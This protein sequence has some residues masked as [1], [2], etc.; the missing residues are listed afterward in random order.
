MRMLILALIFYV[1]ACEK[2]DDKDKRTQKD[3]EKAGAQPEGTETATP[4]SPSGNTLNPSASIQLKSSDMIA[5]SIY[6]TLGRGKT[7][8]NDG[9]TTT[10]VTEEFKKNFGGTSGLRLGEI[11]ADSPST[12]YLLALTI[13][14]ELAARR[15]MEDINAGNGELCQCSTKEDADAMLKRALPHLNFTDAAL[16]SISDQF[17]STCAQDPEGAITSLIGSL[18]FATRI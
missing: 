6:A 18:A 10:D 9:Q 14:A 11:Y 2:N 15:C 8:R 4:E 17:S 1:S 5:Q 16:S 12:S 3:P 13:V 7:L